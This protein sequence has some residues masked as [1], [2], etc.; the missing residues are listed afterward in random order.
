MNSIDFK[1]VKTKN[2]SS[3]AVKNLSESSITNY[4]LPLIVVS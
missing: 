3:M 4:S 2:E 1:S